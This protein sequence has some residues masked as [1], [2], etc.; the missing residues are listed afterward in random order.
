MNSKLI[1]NRSAVIIAKDVQVFL[2]DPVQYL[3]FLIFFGILMVYIINMKNM[4][5][6]ITNPFWKNLITYLNLASICLILATLS[7]RFIFPQISLEGKGAWVISMTPYK[8]SKLILIKFVYSFVF[9]FIITA[10]MIAVSNMMLKINSFTFFVTSLIYFTT[11]ITLCALS[12]GLGAIFPNFKAHNSAAI[13]SGFGG[14]FTLI[15]SLFYVTLSVSIPAFMEHLHIKS[16]MDLLTLK[17]S[18]FVFLICH[19]L[20]SGYITFYVLKKGIRNLDTLDM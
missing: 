14:T 1:T 18:I 20:L 10:P 16:Y 9:S 6:D 15:I 5:Y 8:F 17:S 3:Q 2:R 4:H 13:V 12:I 11:L 19:I 7:T